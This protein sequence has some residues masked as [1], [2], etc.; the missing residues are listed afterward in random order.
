MQPLD[1]LWFCLESI[2]GLCLLRSDWEGRL[3]HELPAAEPF[4]RPT[5]RTSRSY[6]CPDTGGGCARR[7][8]VH[9]TGE[10]VA[11]CGE[12]PR[13][14]ERVVL[15]KSDVLLYRFDVQ[16]LCRELARLLEIEP[17]FEAVTGT[18][19]TWAVGV[20]SPPQGDDFLVYL[21]IPL[22]PEDLLQAVSRLVGTSRERFLLLAPTEESR[23][24]A[25][26]ELLHRHN[27]RFRTLKAVVAADPQGRLVAAQPLHEVFEGLE[28]GPRDEEANIFQLQDEAWTIRYSGKKVQLEDSKGLRLLAVLLREPVREFSP[29]K[30]EAAAGYALPEDP[31]IVRARQLAA[32]L[33]SD[34]LDPSGEVLDNRALAEFKSRLEE[35]KA[36]LVDAEADHDLGAC[37]SLRDERK[38]IEDQ[39]LTA[40][41]LHGRTRSLQDPLKATRDRVRNAINRALDRIRKHHP[42]L[43]QHLVDSLTRGKHWSYRPTPPVDWIV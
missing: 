2:P 14:C 24:L 42:D 3:G 4:L 38:F 9:D 11:V 30:L 12:S 39:L 27:A 25:T 6:P 5:D 28:L 34:G 36:D 20:R 7:V 19:A 13:R 8:V 16:T 17:Q 23:D 29:T 40:R 21:T 18:G 31:R 22:E 1:R 26:R 41:G 35:I 15:S 10:V 33:P 37:E 43:A 32:D